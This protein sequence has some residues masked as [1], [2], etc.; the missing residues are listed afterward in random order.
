MHSE[1]EELRPKLK[2]V[3]YD[4]A[5]DIRAT[6]AA[7]YLLDPAVRKFE[8][9][10]EY[11]FR[12]GVRQSATFNDPLIDR[13]QRGRTPFFVNNV[14]GDPRLSDLMFD[15]ASDRLMAVPLYSRGL[16]VG[17]IDMRDKAAKQPFEQIDVS[18]AQGIAEKIMGLLA[19][20]NLWNQRFITLSDEGALP[21]VAAV[22][23]RETR[24]A[25][26]EAAEA[27]P[28]LREAAPLPTAAPRDT[29]E[30][31]PASR[32][33]PAP[34]QRAEDRLAQLV[35]AARNMTSRLITTPPAEPVG[36][37]ALAAARDIL[38]ELLQL[39]GA[40]LAAFTVTPN[41]AQHIVARGVVT[42]DAL[43]SVRNKLAAWMAKRGESAGALKTTLLPAAGTAPVKDSDI[44]KVF[45]APVLSQTFRGL[46]LTAGFAD[47]P[48]RTTHELLAA[49]LARLQL[50]IEEG[51][52]REALQRF[53]ARAAARLVEPD[54]TA[55]P[56]LRR[57]SEAVAAR[58]AAFA[59]Y[60]GL[61]A[62]DVETVTLTA[63]VHDAGMRMLD[64]DRLYRKRDLSADE[65]AL[66]R[67]HA[68]VGA[69]MVQPILGNDIARAVLCH[70]E[71]VDGRGYPH[72]LQGE[73]I[74][75]VARIVQICD[76][77]VAITDPAT[78]QAVETHADA[79]AAIARGA[80]VQFDAELANRFSEMANVS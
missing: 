58:S 57:H 43:N 75:L 54:F 22:P 18:K 56:D 32:E 48:D 72:E 70:H 41:G 28:A 44:Q 80:G 20:K 39:P 37:A 31:R 14:A 61:S 27:T 1:V 12:T 25:P 15:G 67:E 13:C 59:Q 74:P 79:L 49:T 66:L 9:V 24:D 30:A 17:V 19:P 36:D 60:I 11:G 47:N 78:Y 65:L 21:S 45:T 76:A 2:E 26:R 8:L 71:R 73:E 55:Y 23:S 29:R 52:S 4:C 7:L 46:Y 38:G 10:A 63:L 6:K 53:R 34:P 64:Y 42:E 33:A 5:V 77:Y 62:A 40:V 35:V 68:A 51:T 16:L 69:A 50:A 3:L